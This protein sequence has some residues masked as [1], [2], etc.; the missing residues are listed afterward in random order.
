[1]MRNV[2]AGAAAGA[3]GTT[4]LN[5]VTYLDMVARGRGGSSAPQQLVEQLSDRTGVPVPGEGETR[6]NR[7]TGV[8]A[9]LGMLTGVGVGTLYGAARALGRGPG[10]PLAGLATGMAAMAASDV[11]LAALRVSDPRTWRPADWL[12]DL[13][14]HLTYGAVTAAVYA[15][16]APGHKEPCPGR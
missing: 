10:P 6:E 11:P 13:V 5:A 4:A 2:L 3:A 15:M 9:V 1:M 8:S 16:A 12:A 14:P 7:T